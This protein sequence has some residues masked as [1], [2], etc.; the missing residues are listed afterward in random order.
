MSAQD[1]GSVQQPHAPAESESP[2]P[3]EL[4]ADIEQ[5]RDELGDTVEALAAKTDVKAR[6]HARVDEAKAT[7]AGKKDELTAKVKQRAPGGSAGGDVGSAGGSGGPQQVAQ[8]AL[9]SVKRKPL[10]YIVGGA[11]ALGYLIGRGRG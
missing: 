4:R 11:A 6:A 2:T 7:V 1:P 5:T 3:E 10:P 8:R 9:D